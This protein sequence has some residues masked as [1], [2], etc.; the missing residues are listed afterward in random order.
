MAAD[1][2]DSSELILLHAQAAMLD[3]KR[4]CF[5]LERCCSLSIGQPTQLT[6]AC[7]VR[8]EP[9]SAFQ[10]PLSSCGNGGITGGALALLLLGEDVHSHA[11]GQQQDCKG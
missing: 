6:N 11:S 4:P 2:E 9:A 3:F 5:S 7:F 1:G 10:T 8:H